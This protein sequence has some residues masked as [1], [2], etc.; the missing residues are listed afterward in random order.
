M[1]AI[2]LNWLSEISYELQETS[3]DK[4]LDVLRDADLDGIFKD[5]IELTKS[6][7]SD[8]VLFGVERVN[9][10]T[11]ESE[12][13]GYVAEGEFE[14]DGKGGAQISYGNN[15]EYR[16]TAYLTNSEEVSS[17]FNVSLAKN[18]SIIKNIKQ[19]RIPHTISQIRPKRH[20]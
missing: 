4:I 7:L 10:T 13:L 12:F 6:S 8:I 9:L 15:Y 16:V 5:Q 3:T 1:R 11:S 18:T 2:L 20:S 17:S 14:D 19:V